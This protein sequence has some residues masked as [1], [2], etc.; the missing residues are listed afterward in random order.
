MSRAYEE[1]HPWITF[2]FNINKFSRR[3]WMLLGEAESKCE[4][5]AGVPLR[6]ADAAKLYAVYLSKGIHGTTSIEGN[7]LSEQ[8]VL[9][10]LRGELPLPPSREY[11]GVEV[12]N[13]LNAYNLI[14]NQLRIGQPLELS[15]ERIA[16]FNRLILTGLPL[17]EGVQPGEIRRHNVGVARYRAVPYEDCE[18]LLE[19][20]C[21]WLNEDFENPPDGPFAFTAAVLRAIFAHIYLAWIHPFGDGNGRVARLIE[22]QLLVQAGVPVPS[23]HVLSDHYNKT[24]TQYYRVLDR[25]SRPD[26]PVEDFVEY[27][28]VGMVDELRDQINHIKARQLEVTWQNY[29]HDVF[30]DQE[31]PAKRR[32]KHLVLD[33]PAGQDVPVNEIPRISTRLAEEY[34]GRGPRAVARDLNELEQTGLIL[35]RHRTVRANRELIEAFLAPRAD[36]GSAATA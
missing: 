18:Y 6:P 14:L 10:R 16:E 31:T 35:R 32:Q 3:I 15:P 12:D 30:R 24:R 2:D 9:A 27:A 21:K 5:V 25:I 28:M 20:L 34:A 1:S 22:F 11:L 19:R 29:V 33:L 13:I 17:D 4:H 23:A 7:T 8:E 26:Y 36:R